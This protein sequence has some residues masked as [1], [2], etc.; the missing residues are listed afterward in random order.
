MRSPFYEMKFAIVNTILASASVSAMYA[1][2]GDNTYCR[3]SNDGVYNEVKI[4]DVA[5]ASVCLTAC[6]SSSYLNDHQVGFSY[7]AIDF[8]CWCQYENNWGPQGNTEAGLTHSGPGSGP[9]GIP[10]FQL[11]YTVCYTRNAFPGNPSPPD[12]ESPSKTPT[13]AP[14]SSPSKTPTGIPSKTPTS[15]PNVGPT[16]SPTLGPSSS[17]VA[18]GAAASLT[19]TS[20]GASLSSVADSFYYP[21]WSKSNGGCKTGGGQPMYMTSDP[22]TWMLATLEDCCL[23]YYGWMLNECKGASGGAP[24][25]LWYPDWAGSDDTCKNDGGEPDYMAMNPGSWMHSSKQSCCEANFSWELNE[26]ISSS[27]TAT[28]KWYMIWNAQF[29]CKK[30]CVNGPSC[31][32]RANP[33]DQLYETRS[34]CCANKAAWDPTNCLTD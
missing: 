28:N 1:N 23:R 30:D 34:A 8:K 9:V 27:N 19:S 15:G 24:A 31:G 10:V 4:E 5:S 20:N 13:G 33:W 29:K 26:C 2:Q 11:Q 12:T 17:G 22:S 3:A 6:S 32:G 21:D 16:G 7:R 25:G 14:T 18:G